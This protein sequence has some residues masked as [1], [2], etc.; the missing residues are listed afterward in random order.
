M[1]VRDSSAALQQEVP[2]PT[3]QAFYL[4]ESLFDDAENY[5][6]LQEAMRVAAPSLPYLGTVFSFR[7]SRSI[8]ARSLLAR[9]LGLLA[10]FSQR[11]SLQ[12]A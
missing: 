1:A 10:D 3:R 8:L 4:L 12:S 2:T 6:V 7:S 9:L 5:R 11:D